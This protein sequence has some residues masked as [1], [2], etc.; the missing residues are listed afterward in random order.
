M[1]RPTFAHPVFEQLFERD[2]FIEDA[3]LR[4]ILVL[5][6]ETA[7]PELLKIVDTALASYRSGALAG[8]DWLDNY[9]FSHVLYLLHE[10][11]APEALDV[12]RRLLRLDSV[13]SDFW[14]GDALFE[15]V[16]A[17]LAHAGQT[18]LTE[19]L[20]LLEDEQLLLQHRL[21]A[22]DS[23]T[24]LAREQPALRPAISAF[25]QQHLRH[26]IAHP[27]QAATLFPAD[28]DS[29][30]YTA[31]DYLGGLL[32]DAQ[33]AGFSELEPEMRELHRLGLVDEDIAGG[34]DD[35]TFDVPYPLVPA[36]DIFSRYQQL[37]DDPDNYSPFHPDAAGIALRRAQQEARYARLRRD[38]MPRQVLPKI[39][40]NDPCPCGSGKKYKKCCGA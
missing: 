21:V 30:G 24:L 31:E 6:P 26:I 12:Y 36:P 40:R 4:E 29:Y 17:L 13:A 28:A 20:A 37:R 1:T 9:Y 16:P 39:G 8:T 38:S 2:Y 34:E 18:R 27:D 15:E 33:D 14:F 3:V 22:A 10:L 23:I 32:A 5:G 19:L 11:Q 35:I 7:V 25:L